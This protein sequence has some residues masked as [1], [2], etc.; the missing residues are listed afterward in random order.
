MGL[1]SNDLSHGLNVVGSIPTLRARASCV[2]LFKH[3]KY[4]FSNGTLLGQI[5][6]FHLPDKL[7]AEDAAVA[8]RA[9]FALGS[10]LQEIIYGAGTPVLE[11]AEQVPVGL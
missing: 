1:R 2:T 5:L 7:C 3:T 6:I 11:V 9:P 8:D 10:V 4:V